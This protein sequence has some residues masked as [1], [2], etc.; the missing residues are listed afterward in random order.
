MLTAKEETLKRRR[1]K[2]N[3]VQNVETSNIVRDVSVSEDKK[4]VEVIKTTLK[5]DNNNFEDVY[6]KLSNA[7]Y[8]LALA[9]EI[10]EALLTENIEVKKKY[11]SLLEEHA[12]QVEV[13]FTFVGKNIKMIIVP[14]SLVLPMNGNLNIATIARHWPTRL[15]EI[16]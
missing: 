16:T 7:E 6:T 9:T 15:C 5:D 14:C 4:Q 13:R 1:S 10:G 3:L 2:C 11:D 12:L 8:N